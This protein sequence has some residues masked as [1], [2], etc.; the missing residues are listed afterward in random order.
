MNEKYYKSLGLT[1]SATDDEVKEA[2]L[3]LKQKYKAERFEEG[4]VGNDAA[5]RL[6]E[7]EVAYNAIMDSRSQQFTSEKAGSLYE[8]IEALLK[9]GDV[10]TA[11][12][13]LDSFDERSA[14]WHYLQSVVFYKKSWI[15][16]SK[17]QLEIAVSMDAD[18]KKYS[19]ALQKMTETVNKANAQA[20]TNSGS[21]AS[22]TNYSSTDNT[23][24]DATFDEQ[25]LG[26]NS[27]M[28]WCCQ[29][30]ACNLLLNCC[31]NCH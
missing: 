18:N 16:E 4:K 19:D 9:S 29:M 5:K 6:T 11:Q 8:E 14:E 31:C 30:L 27:C 1:S 10:T 23:V 24:D 21:T 26:G 25:Q 12:Q 7:I 3:T 28:Q 20:N 17:K 22:S 2:Y 15:N 13:K